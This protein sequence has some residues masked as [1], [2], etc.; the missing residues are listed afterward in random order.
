MKKLALVL[1]AILFF[2]STASFAYS[3]PKIVEEKQFVCHMNDGNGLQTDLLF[4]IELLGILELPT[5][6]VLHINFITASELAPF[7]KAIL[8]FFNFQPGE[9]SQFVTGFGLNTYILKSTPIMNHVPATQD[10]F[11]ITQQTAYV[12][13]IVR[14]QDGSASSRTIS[15]PTKISVVG[16]DQKN[17]HI[18]MQISYLP[19]DNNFNIRSIKKL[20]NLTGQCEN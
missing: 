19:E 7:H 2:T 12:N 17:T 3:T 4:K 20:L 10:L 8:K 13:I 9:G 5:Y 14:N 6:R 16:L 15:L 1:P 18:N 11:K